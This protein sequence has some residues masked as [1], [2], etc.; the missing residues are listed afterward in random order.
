M[1][2]KVERVTL[3]K[4]F[5][6]SPYSLAGNFVMMFI[7]GFLFFNIVPI[8]M[9]LIGL[10][11]H[12]FVLFY[13]TAICR[14]Y[15]KN[16]DKI[17]DYKGLQKYKRYYMI[18]TFLSGLVWGLSIIL[19]FF[20]NSIEYQFFL[21]MVVIGMA[22]ASTVTLSAVFQ[23]YIA[24]IAPMLG[25][26]ATYA[27]MQ[28]GDIYTATSL[29]IIGLMFFFYFSGKNYYKVLVDSIIDRE[30]ILNTQYEIVNRL[31]K[32]GE[33]RDSETGMHITRMSYSCHLLAKEC[34][35]HSEL[36]TNILYA[37]EMHDIGKIG[38]PDEILL[39]QGK[40]DL[41]ERAIME[42]HVNIG[43]KILENSDSKLIKLSESIA[44]THHEKYDG[45]GYPNS[46]KASAIPIEGRITAICDVF[47]ALVSERPYK[48][49]WTHQDAIDYITQESSKHFD[50]DLVKKFV[51]I[52]PEIKT[53]YD[54]HA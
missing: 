6:M 1:N 46:L 18:G 49:A 9:I 43:K 23:V 21:Y 20:E 44:Y 39:K 26:S 5:K 29:F 32:A 41:S 45:T 53:F 14:S 35:L 8:Y 12:M 42:E 30:S 27:F 13:R 11:M 17:L 3:D 24:F 22:G 47:D 40:L 4:L 54:K 15:S 36:I 31:S 7:V 50:P 16:K 33:Y 48:K 10:I 28:E 38:I 2:T 52:Y 37:S 19:L 25:I 34:N 51:L